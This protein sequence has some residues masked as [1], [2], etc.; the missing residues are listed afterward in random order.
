LLLL[1]DVA[2][3]LSGDSKQILLVARPTPRSPAL[4]SKKK[5]LV[6][7]LLSMLQYLGGLAFEQ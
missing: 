7:G 3:T 4:Q 1:L 5:N 6:E 2:G